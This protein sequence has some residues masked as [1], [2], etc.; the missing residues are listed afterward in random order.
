MLDVF[1]L[2]F[3][4]LFLSIVFLPLL[5]VVFLLGM[6][7]LVLLLIVVVVAMLLWV[8]VFFADYVLFLLYLMSV[9]LCFWHV[10]IEVKLHGSLSIVVMVLLLCL[11][12]AL[13]LLMQVM[14]DV[15]P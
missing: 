7:L 13:P 4:L 15:F 14:M 11:M 8:L 1:L 2:L 12:A 10:L 5:V 9:L 3:V 6:L